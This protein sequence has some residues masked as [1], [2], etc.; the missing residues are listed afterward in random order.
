MSQDHAERRVGQDW[1]DLQQIK[2]RQMLALDHIQL[3][4][5][6]DLQ[7]RLVNLERKVT[8]EIYHCMI[9]RSMLRLC[10]DLLV[11]R[12][13]LDLKDHEEREGSGA[14]SAPMG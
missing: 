12:E 6:R 3:E 1:M 9:L 2:C 13:I 4:E 8:R 14:A 7:D 5:Y 10:R 11:T